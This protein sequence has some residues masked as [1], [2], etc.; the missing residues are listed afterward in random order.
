M[1]DYVDAVIKEIERSRADGH[2]LPASTLF[3]GGGTPSLLS[4]KDIS[5]LIAAVELGAEAEV[6]VECNP[7]SMTPELMRAIKD[8]A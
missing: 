1:G 8:S 3:L 5:R 6:T 7:E 4:P 2:L